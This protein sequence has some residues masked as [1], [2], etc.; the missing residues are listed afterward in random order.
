MI[1]E[2]VADT[3][4]GLI[5]RA[6]GAER[7]HRPV[8]ER[9]AHHRISACLS[10]HAPHKPVAA[11]RMPHESEIPTK[12]PRLVRWPR[13]LDVRLEAK[14]ARLI[15]GDPPPDEVAGL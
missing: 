7:L 6:P 11:L 13:S 8:G 14:N 15:D 12:V 1:P 4:H 5:N 3:R 10:N 2:P 9:H